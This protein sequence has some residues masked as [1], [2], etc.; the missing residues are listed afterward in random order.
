MNVMKFTTIALGILAV[1]GVVY[2]GKFD[3]LSPVVVSGDK[4]LTVIKN[5]VPSISN[6]IRQNA[7][8]Q[9]TLK[10]LGFNSIYGDL[11]KSLQG[12]Q[13]QNALETDASGNLII[14]DSIQYIFDYFLSANGE[15]DIEK[16][17]LR[18]NEYLEHNLQEP[19]L[20]Q[21]KTILKQY[22]DLKYSLV[23][24]EGDMSNQ[25][26]MLDK[27][28]LKGGQYV[29]LLRERLNQ[30]NELRS[31]Y[32]DSEVH[33]VFY[34]QEE[35]YDEYTYNRL[36]INSDQSLSLEERQMQTSM[37]HQSLPEVVQDAMRVTLLANDL[38]AQTQKIIEEGGSPED[39]QA[40][41]AELFG[42]ESVERFEELDKSRED[43]NQRLSAYMQQRE[44]ILTNQGLTEPEQQ[45]QVT[46]L[47][48]DLFNSQEQIRVRVKEGSL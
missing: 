1:S 45:L 24:L 48:S 7:N 12:T 4:S 15:E 23:D 13:L 37:L 6:T 30:R 25:L 27:G 40:F 16:I 31:L 44:M 36:L 14:T 11:P 9:S 43:W 29:S 35:A 46:D 17:L 33:K 22:V 26:D 3:V 18:M 10:V 2:I 19:A 38:E 32:L 34:A 47:R 21:A 39:I 20:W 41:R 8:A 5:E 28:N 42:E